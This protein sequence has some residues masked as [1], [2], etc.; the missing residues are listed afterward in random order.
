VVLKEIAVKKAEHALQN[1]NKKFNISG[2]MSGEK[3]SAQQNVMQEMEASMERAERHMQDGNL[4]NAGAVLDA[5]LKLLPL[6]AKRT[7]K[8]VKYPMSSKK[9]DLL[10]AEKDAKQSYQEA[11][12][13]LKSDE[14]VVQ[15]GKQNVSQVEAEEHQD[16]MI[17]RRQKAELQESQQKLA[18]SHNASKQLHVQDNA[19]FNKVSN[20]KDKLEVITKAVAQD[21]QGTVV[22]GDG[23]NHAPGE[24][25]DD[26]NL[27]A[28][29]GCD[30]ECKVEP[31][32][33]CSNVHKREI[34]H[35]HELELENEKENEKENEDEH[36]HE[37]EHK[38]RNPIELGAAMSMCRPKCGD[39][40]RFPTER[41]DDGNS[42]SGDGC[43]AACLVE[44][45]WTCSGG[46]ASGKVRSLCEKCGN[47]VKRQGESCDDGNLKNGDGCSENCQVETGFVC[48][49]SKSECQAK[50]RFHATNNAKRRSQ[51]AECGLKKKY[52][53][54]KS[55][56]DLTG[57]CVDMP[58][59]IQP[60]QQVAVYESY[61]GA[62]LSGGNTAFT[63]LGSIAVKPVFEVLADESADVI[64]ARALCRIYTRQFCFNEDGQQHCTVTSS[65]ECL[66]VAVQAE[67]CKSNN[68]GA[69]KF[70]TYFGALACVF[71]GC[72]VPPDWLTLQNLSVKP[73]AWCYGA[74]MREFN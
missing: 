19:T 68:R 58:F 38:E 65:T 34:E 67:F 24:Q 56:S 66:E 17:E 72:D 54:T 29:D 59:S 42:Q 26:G 7:T 73:R 47:G 71:N 52:F 12:A 62:E 39:G 40:R 3:R 15:S 13:L 49:G 5:Q 25:C 8:R 70:R 33:H 4:E 36:E 21:L 28:G 48:F 22:C 43:S 50:S 57:T 6:L 31:G 35:K 61:D 64:D 27:D 53:V 45:T 9:D 32:W 41:C 44:K 74:A 14:A 30:Q 1:E 23:L 46:S 60:Q 18:Q 11:K 37:H 2:I 55:L 69:L 51:E 10:H 63:K 16:K 20:E